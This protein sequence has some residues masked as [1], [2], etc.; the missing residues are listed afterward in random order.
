M[1]EAAIKNAKWVAQQYGVHTLLLIGA[2]WYINQQNEIY[3]QQA[4]SYAATRETE[5]GEWKARVLESDD[6]IKTT[7]ADTLANNTRG[8]QELSGAIRELRQEIARSGQ[9]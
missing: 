5:I 6:Y 7:L 2:L 9:R 1:S 4:E 8:F 3:R